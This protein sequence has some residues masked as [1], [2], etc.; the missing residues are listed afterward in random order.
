MKKVTRINV[1]GSAINIIPT[2]FGDFIS[3]TDMVKN[4]E[5][6][7]V[8]FEKWLRNKN[9][10]EFIGMWEQLNNT[11]F[12]SPEFGEIRN[13]AELNRFSLSVKKWIQKTKSLEWNF[14]RTFAK[15]NNRIHT[16]AIKDHLIPARKTKV[17]LNDN[18]ISQIRSLVN[19]NKADKMI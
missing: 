19:T 18:A 12:N 3:L 7:L 5:Y 14:H 10:I 2:E 8:L 13:E 17:Q 15:V 9:T 1:K 4:Y 11:N 16:D 6:G